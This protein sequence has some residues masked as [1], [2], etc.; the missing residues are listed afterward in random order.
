MNSFKINKKIRFDR[1][2]PTEDPDYNHER[3][4]EQQNR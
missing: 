4:Q 3:N 1:R 2:R